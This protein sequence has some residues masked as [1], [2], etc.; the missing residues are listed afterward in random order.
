MR[1]LTI[2]K[3]YLLF[4]ILFLSLFFFDT[5]SGENNTS[6]LPDN[7]TAKPIIYQIGSYTIT[8]DEAIGYFIFA[9]VVII[10]IAWAMKPTHKK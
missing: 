3:K 5:V 8:Q 10:V 4:T 9:I 2:T 7:T 6:E 1:R